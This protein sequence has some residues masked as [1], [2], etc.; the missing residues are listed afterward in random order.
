M[1]DLLW[2]KVLDSCFLLSLVLLQYLPFNVQK[3]MMLCVLSN[4]QWR[5]RLV[6]YRA[7]L[8]WDEMFKITL[9]Y[10]PQQK[11]QKEHAFVILYYI[12]RIAFCI[13]K[14]LL[15]SHHH[16]D[17]VNHFKKARNYSAHNSSVITFVLCSPG[18]LLTLR[19]LLIKWDA[20]FI[21]FYAEILWFVK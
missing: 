3:E 12:A 16:A 13:A 19:V 9:N 15:M 4:K 18:V 5:Q 6:L 2:E 8:L 7:R 14:R 17:M 21:G 11:R 20:C 10:V 1:R